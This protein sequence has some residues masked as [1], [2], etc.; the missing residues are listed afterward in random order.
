M[1]KE[2]SYAA[3]DRLVNRFAR[4]LTDLGIR[5]GDT[6]AMLLPNIPQIVIA[7]YAAWR[8]GAVT[9]MNNPLYTE[10]ELEHQFNLS[11]ARLVV[12]LDLLH[13]R[14]VK[15]LD[16][17]SVEKIVVCHINDYLGFP[18]KQLFPL[19][20]KEMYRKIAPRPDTFEF[21][22][23]VAAQDDTPLEKPG[24]PRCG[25]RPPVHRRHHRGQ[26][27]RHDHPPQHELQHPA[28]P[29]LVL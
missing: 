29:A 27:G 11:D 6:V 23:L 28:A 13:P 21:S 10:R 18:K 5:A 9:A 7:N 25:G 1:G 16:T 12:T 8:I 19:V 2:I 4:A 15:L 3:L 17:T 24:R 20:K 14:A 22:A 26:Q